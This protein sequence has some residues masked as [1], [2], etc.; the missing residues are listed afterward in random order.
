MGTG[1]A[2][3]VLEGRVLPG[4]TAQAVTRA[5]GLVVIVLTLLPGHPAAA[6]T[7]GQAA[8]I[9]F[10]EPVP[11]T[12]GERAAVILEYATGARECAGPV[13]IQV[14]GVL[15]HAGVRY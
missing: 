1:L 15:R 10:P 2:G 12:A 4:S 11:V 3:R 13:L 14:T 9:A 5:G 7:E 8:E 6:L